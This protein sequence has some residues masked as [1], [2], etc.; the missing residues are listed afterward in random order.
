MGPRRMLDIS[1]DDA[2]DAPGRIH[3]YGFGTIRCG[4]VIPVGGHARNRISLH[5][6]VAETPDGHDPDRPIR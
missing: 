1:L 5:I 2:D 4:P 6:L 3:I